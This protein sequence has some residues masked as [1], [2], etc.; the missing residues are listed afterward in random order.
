MVFIF[1]IISCNRVKNEKPKDDGRLCLEEN[2]NIK[3]RYKNSFLI[4]DKLSGNLLVETESSVDKKWNLVCIYNNEGV[5]IKK[6]N[7]RKIDRQLIGHYYEFHLNSFLKYYC[8][9]KPNHSKDSILPF[10]LFSNNIG[11]IDSIHGNYLVDTI[12]NK[13]RSSIKLVFPKIDH[14]KN[15]FIVNSY[16]ST[17]SNLILEGRYYEV[18][19]INSFQIDK[20]AK[21]LEVIWRF[22]N[23][24]HD[25][26]GTDKSIINIE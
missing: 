14:F 25:E 18:S 15:E 8:Y 9:Y 10:E 2:F 12:F 21:S 11:S 7:I 22:D 6:Y 3:T 26:F 13:T 23:L 24:F 17:G 19:E 5:L 4:I 1:V 16:D 20:N